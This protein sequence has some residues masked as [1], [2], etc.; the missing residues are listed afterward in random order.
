MK[1]APLQGP[2][3]CLERVKVAIVARQALSGQSVI[4]SPT[5]LNAVSASSVPK[6][7]SARRVARMHF[8]SARIAPID[9]RITRRFTRKLVNS[10]DLTIVNA[11]GVSARVVGVGIVVGVGGH[12]VAPF[13]PWGVCRSYN[14]I[15]RITTTTYKGMHTIY[16]FHYKQVK[17]PASAR[18]FRL[19]AL[20]VSALQCL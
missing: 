19:Y 2:C 3:S 12:V 20:S 6:F 5:N 15:I 7:L 1:K 16:T 13:K 8:V 14:F 11:V 18:A 10:R 17:A 4:P 9:I